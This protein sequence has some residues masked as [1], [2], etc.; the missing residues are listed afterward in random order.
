LG[1]VLMNFLCLVQENLPKGGDRHRTLYAN[2]GATP[3]SVE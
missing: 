2:D 3:Y 1:E